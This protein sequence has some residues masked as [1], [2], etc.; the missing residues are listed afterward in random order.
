[1]SHYLYNIFEVN[2]P[3]KCM[4]EFSIN[5]T[6]SQNLFKNQNSNNNQTN[7]NNLVNIVYSI[8][9]ISFIHIKP[10]ILTN[11]FKQVLKK[12]QE[13]IFKQYP[14]LA[15]VYCAELL[16]QKQ[17]K[18]IVYNQKIK[19]QFEETFDKFHLEFHPNTKEKKVSICR[20]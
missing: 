5:N 18:W 20:S 11:N 7:T 14:N 3:E 15:Y 10:W 17:V 12:F 4:N 19:Y 16:Y 9:D 2:I 13:N 1:M 8:N 6:Q